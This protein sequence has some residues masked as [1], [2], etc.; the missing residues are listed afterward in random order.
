MTDT[1]RRYFM[2]QESLNLLQKNIDILSQKYDL[3]IKSGNFG[4]ALNIMKNIDA[5]T[6]QLDFIGQKVTITNDDTYKNPWYDILKFFIENKMPQ[7]IKLNY[8]TNENELKHKG[9]GKTT[10]LLRLSQDYNIPIFTDN[11]QRFEPELKRKAKDLNLHIK[12]LDYKMLNMKQ[13]QKD[14][15]LLVDENTNIDNIDGFFFK[16]NMSL[17]KIIIGF[18]K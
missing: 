11:Y 5:L 15:V 16:G 4:E 6:R 17:P 8:S 12:V 13:F 10:A 3:T 18:T 9:T 14:E 1:S 2:K 7:L